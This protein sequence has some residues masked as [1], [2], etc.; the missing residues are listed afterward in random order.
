MASESKIKIIMEADDKATEPINRATEAVQELGKETE[1]LTRESKKNWSGLADLFGTVL[2]RDLKR[3]TRGFKGTQRQVGRLAKGFKVLRTAW[4][5]IGIGLIIVAL[6]QIVSNW[7]KISESLGLYN[8]EAEETAK[9]NTDIKVS[10]DELIRQTQAYRAELRYATYG[11]E[12][13][14]IAVEGLNRILGNG[15]DIEAD[16]QTQNRQSNALLEAN[17]KLIKAKKKAEALELKAHVEG[18]EIRSRKAKDRSM[19]DQLSQGVAEWRNENEKEITALTNAAAKA[20]AAEVEAEAALNAIITKTNKTIDERT[21]AE[22]EAELE[23]KKSI[24]DK[25][26]DAKWLAGQRVQM[27]QET[28]LRLIKDEEQRDLR[29]LEM[30]HE[31]A[32]TELKARGGTKEDLEA[33]EKKH[34]LDMAE[35]VKDYQDKADEAQNILDE[36]AAANREMVR[37]ALA[38]EEEN[39]L[40]RL[41]DK[42]VEE[43]LAAAGN[44]EA[45]F[46][47]DEKYRD[48][49][50]AVRDKYDKEE[51][52]AEQK[53]Q[54]AKLAAKKKLVGSVSGLLRELG[55][56]AEEGSEQQK[57]LAI[58]D[59][60]VNQAMA[61]AN[62]VAA[63]A[64]ASKEGGPA[65]PFLFAAYVATMLGTIA[66]TFTSIKSI[67]SDADAPTPSGGGM[68]S[69]G[70]F[71]PT[72]QVPLPA[73]I[74]SPDSLQAYVVQS[75]LQGQMNAQGKL[76]GQIVL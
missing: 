3:L 6:E 31:A 24:A 48:D 49:E 69:R 25:K 8:K 76:H 61:M 68:G 33:L 21:E 56:A 28:E 38:T 46:K 74:D 10:T 71:A 27:A 41:K 20:K 67:M 72:A 34:G 57:R 63:A 12:E 52:E 43:Q 40:K 26:A 14:K 39:E 30:Q 16:R 17:T 54:D 13:H 22:R 64:K 32:K 50:K 55:D 42:Y 66:S 35:I 18:E 45:L 4:A 9:I 29:R 19:W 5:S 58:A 51:L 53:L 44:F 11:S 65:A 36:E 59:V 73:R 7:D 70:G 47:L 37:A 75:Q 15:I 2:P 1:K 60:L 62:A 23:R